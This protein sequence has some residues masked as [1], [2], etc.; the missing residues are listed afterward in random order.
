MGGGIV[1]AQM[2][3]SRGG[4]A[5]RIIQFLLHVLGA[6]IRIITAPF[7]NA[8]AVGSIRYGVYGG[9][10]I[11]SNFGY[12]WTAYGVRRSIG[13]LMSAARRGGVALVRQGAPLALRAA[14]AAGTVATGL[15]RSGVIDPLAGH[16]LR[17]AVRAVPAQWRG[18]R[19]RAGT[20][21]RRRR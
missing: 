16:V 3:Y 1:G 5:A 15:V 7:V 8:F 14:A 9:P 2:A 18:G 20:G 11:P 10:Q 17:A 19:R 21:R 13:M 12:A 4:R 6:R